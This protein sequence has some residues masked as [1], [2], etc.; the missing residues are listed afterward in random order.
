[1]TRP[2]IVVGAI[3]HARAHWIQVNVAK[4]L[5]QI[6][7]DVDQHRVVTLLEKMT[8]RVQSGESCAHSVLR[9]A[10]STARAALHLL[11]SAGEMVVR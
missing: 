9:Y 10:A 7:I 3:D 6:L 11:V 5:Q 4:Q 2:R 1:M 8:G